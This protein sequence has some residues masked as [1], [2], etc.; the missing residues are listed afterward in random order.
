V[1]SG[2]GRTLSLLRVA[3]AGVFEVEPGRWG[4]GGCRCCWSRLTEECYR[5]RTR[6]PQRHKVENL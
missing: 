1:K 2:D 4:R 6:P 3:C 5:K